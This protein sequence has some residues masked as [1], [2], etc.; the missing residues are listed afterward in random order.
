MFG[1]KYS[2]LRKRSKVLVALLAGMG[3]ITI[4]TSTA[5]ADWISMNKTYKVFYGVTN[6]DLTDSTGHI[7]RKGTKVASGDRNSE[8]GLSFGIMQNMPMS[9][10]FG[11][12]PSQF[13]TSTTSNV[14]NVPKGFGQKFLSTS[15][16]T[17][18]GRYETL[19]PV[20][21]SA[22][23]KKVSPNKAKPAPKKVTTP[24]LKTT[25]VKKSFV[26]NQAKRN[27][28]L[29]SVAPYGYKGAK[30]AGRMPKKATIY[31]EKKLTDKKKS[32]WYYGKVNGKSVWFDAKGVKAAPAKK[33]TTPTTPKSTIPKI[34][35][36]E[37]NQA[38]RNDG[39]YTGAPYG[40]K[41]AQFA[42]RM[43]KRANIYVEKQVVDKKKNVWFY[44]SVQGKK[45]WF[46]AKAVKVAM[47]R[48]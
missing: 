34:K 13:V 44:G 47:G 15:Y 21:K 16:V 30:F 14:I 42:G 24:A 35:F 27:D 37:A 48:A 17:D 38:K 11:L 45:V 1:K 7:Y 2:K 20:T 3:V 33:T 40:Y 23:K 12:V 5:S 4:G 19:K 26:A 9:I 39:L 8:Y 29:Y 10:C 22:P 6:V 46:D 28:G 36:Y 25:T 41:G 31:V 32:V 43:P 18:A